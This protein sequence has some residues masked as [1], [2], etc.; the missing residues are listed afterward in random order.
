MDKSFLINNLTIILQILGILCIL[1]IIIRFLYIYSKSRPNVEIL[2]EGPFYLEDDVQVKISPEKIM[3]SFEGTEYTL[4]FWLYNRNP[5]ENANWKNEYK[6]I[7]GVINHE[8]SPTV[9]FNPEKSE[10]FVQM[11]YLDEDEILQYERVILPLTKQHWQHFVITIKDKNVDFYIDG[12]LEKGTRLPYEPYFSRKN[13]FLGEKGNQSLLVIANV[14][15]G[16]EWSDS[17]KIRKL[18]KKQ[19]KY[20]NVNREPNTYVE[21]LHKRFS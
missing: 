21:Q 8:L 16:Q 1:L 19:R 12:V 3:K 15:W 13:M 10:L 20:A 4:S 17:N 5:P 2:E 9:F 11:G 7:K 18:Y 6:K 14:A